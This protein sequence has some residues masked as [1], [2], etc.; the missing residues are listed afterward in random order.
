MRSLLQRL[1][2]STAW[3][4]CL[5]I[6]PLFLPVAITAKTDWGILLYALT[7]L[8]LAQDKE[9]SRALLLAAFFLGLGC[10][11]K[12]P[13][14]LG[15]VPLLVYL[16]A[17]TDGKRAPLL[18]G[19]F[20]MGLLPI[21]LRNYYY[22]GSVFFPALPNTWSAAVLSA[23]D[24]LLFSTYGQAWK[25]ISPA[26]FSQRLWHLLSAHPLNFAVFLLPYL[27]WKR[28]LP[29]DWKFLTAT[30]FLSL[31]LTAWILHP[32]LSVRVA[33]P[34]AFLLTLLGLKAI[35]LIPWKANLGNL[36]DWYGPM[37]SVAFLLLILK[38]TL[39]LHFTEPAQAIRQFSAGDSMAWIRLY[40]R[41]D[42]GI[43]FGGNAQLYY[44][45]GYPA[46]MPETSR[47]LDLALSQQTNLRG[48]V[49]ILRSQNFS[50][51]VETSGERPQGRNAGFFAALAQS[52]HKSEIIF[53]G[54]S[55]RIWDLAL[56]E[57]TFANPLFVE[58]LHVPG[59]YILEQQK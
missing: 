13:T 53:S 43:A 28:L 26:V 29:R 38:F 49:K 56:L 33:G 36:P 48:I 35:S 12:W 55:S 27:W 54:S 34:T 10:C 50:L 30:A 22:T 14:V 52:G 16:M 57:K 31:L 4:L 42:G 25:T 20:V 46:V 45:T 15:F 59:G 44:M 5:I 23:H 8:W 40:Y 7:A 21:C 41:G 24:R 6:H 17:T 1:N 11:N 18:L 37:A 39:P 2:L 32:A 3:A 19:L 51:F 58:P 9:N 47:D